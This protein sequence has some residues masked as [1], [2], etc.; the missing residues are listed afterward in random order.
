MTLWAPGDTIDDVSI[1][2]TWT[3]YTPTVVAG[4]GGF[5]L[6][7][8]TLI[9]RWAD[10]GKLIGFS[11][12]LTFGASTALG[13]GATYLFGLPVARDMAVDMVFAAILNDASASTA[14]YRTASGFSYNAQDFGI[15][16][17]E[18]TTGKFVAPAV[19][20]TWAVGDIIRVSGTYVR[21]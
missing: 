17:H 15:I 1:N 19:P 20:W 6:G 10:W 18:G 21:A 16:T 2:G 9:G 11:L 13:T 8:G 3:A 12:R 5:S 7:D 14:G 4:S